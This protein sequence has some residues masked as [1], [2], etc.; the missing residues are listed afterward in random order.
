MYLRS[1]ELSSF[2]SFAA[3]R[4][5]F[6]PEINVFHGPNASGKTNLLEAIYVLSNLRSFRTH[7]LRDLIQWE[8]P[9]AYIRGTIQP[10]REPAA[11]VSEAGKEALPA[12]D[13]TLRPGKTLAVRI[14]PN[15][16][17]ASLNSKLAR[18]SKEYLQV[19]PCTA[20]IPDD[21]SLIK[22][23]PAGRRYFLDRG[24][25]QYY[26]PYWSLLTDYNKILR[27]KNTLLR[28][29][30]NKAG[31]RS[32]E[33]VPAAVAGPCE[34]WNQQLRT[35]GSK[36]I[37]HRL[38]F[39]QN[40]QRVLTQIYNGWLG[41]KEEIA[42]RYKSSLRLA[43]EDF[44]ELSA[45]RGIEEEAM[46]ARLESA[47]A[48]AMQDNLAREYRLG[49]AVI[50]PHRDDLEIELWG[51]ALRSFGSQGQ[52][53]TAVLALK[54]AEV[55][56]YYE[57]YGEYSILLLDDVTAELDAARSHK[58]FEYLQPGM[59]VFISATSKPNLP[60]ARTFACAYFDLS[61]IEP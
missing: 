46:A 20:F 61:E 42:L 16:Q 17:T 15:V 47:F 50:G 1:L 34:V 54:L 9:Q 25:F 41:A 10:G 30:K 24:T 14:E 8:Y 51:R 12:E 33:S 5:E 32:G 19:L 39:V 36:I 3:Q 18:S 22:G 59:Q 2:R 7:L 31:K 45:R 52:Q 23:M 58:L 21:V 43:S 48:Q 38:L 4:C 53:R 37:L 26:P 60:I 13:E 35:V 56:L 44:P 29:F 28:D 57:R 49:A 6:S 55:Y 11:A 40:L 27:Q